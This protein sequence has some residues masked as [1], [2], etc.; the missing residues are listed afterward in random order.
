MLLQLPVVAVV[1]AVHLF[2]DRLRFLDVVPRGRWVL[3]AA[4]A[5]G[6][7][8][9]LATAIGE[10]VIGSLFAFLAGGIVLNVLKEELP[11]ERKSRFAPKS[12]RPSSTC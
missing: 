10:A 5:V 11:E 8:A 4:V 12:R 1:V 2:A 9:G 6:W 7:V 3:A